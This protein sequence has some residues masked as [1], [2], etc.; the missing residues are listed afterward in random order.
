MICS[1]CSGQAPKVGYVDQRFIYNN[2]PE[3]KV[4]IKEMELLSAK[5]ETALKEKYALYQKK[6]DAYEK[7]TKQNSN[8]AILKDKENELVNLQKSIQEFQQNAQQDLKVQFEKAITPLEEKVNNIIA[9]FGKDNK[10][11]YIFRLQVEQPI[12][13]STPYILYAGDPSGNISKE[14]L[15]KLGITPSETG[16]AK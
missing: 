15:L 14:I 12:G 7:E 11:S 8:D 2:L 13:E 9:Q 4:K 6:L 10:Y 1:V 16:T 3:Y 5:Y